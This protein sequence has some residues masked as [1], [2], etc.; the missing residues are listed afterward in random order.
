MEKSLKKSNL[1]LDCG[2]GAGNMSFNI[3]KQIRYKNKKYI[4]NDINLE[5]LIKLKNNFKIFY[6]KIII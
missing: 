5:N 6:L 2:V 3:L 4:A 1:I